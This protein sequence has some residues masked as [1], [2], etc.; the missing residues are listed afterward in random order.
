MRTKST[1]L[2]GIQI[3]RAISVLS[4]LLFHFD[5][6]FSR[7]YLG[8]DIFFVISGFV[9]TR[10]SLTK[11][12]DRKLRQTINF[13]ASRT[14]R[15][16]PAFAVMN[17][18]VLI[19]IILFLSPNLGVQQQAIKSGFGSMLGISN[20][21]IP[22]LTGDYFGTPS[23]LNPYLH[24][25]SLSV[26]EQFYLLFP[27][28]LVLVKTKTR[29]KPLKIFYKFFPEVLFLI[30]LY[31]W[32]NLERFPALASIAPTYF[33]PISRFWEFLAGVIA[34]RIVFEKSSNSFRLPKVFNKAYFIL[35]LALLNLENF[36]PTDILI[37]VVSLTFFMLIFGD[38]ELEEKQETRLEKLLERVGDRSYSIYLWH[39]PIIVI[40]PLAVNGLSH[41]VVLVIALALTLVASEISFRTIEVKVKRQLM[42]RNLLIGITNGV[43]FITV[44]MSMVVGAAFVQS[45]MNQSWALTSHLA[46]KDDC[47]IGLTAQPV[48][49]E[50]T[51]KWEPT[52]SK[53][54]GESI[55]LYGDSLAW[56]GADSA[57]TSANAL[58]Y[59][60]RLFT[61]NGCYARLA[62][63]SD[64]SPCGEWSR[65]VFKEIQ[66]TKPSILI[67]YGNFQ[68]DRL[69]SETLSLLRNL[70]LI[71][72]KTIIVMPPPMGDSF[73]EI[74]GIFNFRIKPD[75]A[76]GR[77][78]PVEIS[79]EFK[80]GLFMTF[81]PADVICSGPVCPI[82]EKGAEL[83][84]YGNHLSVYGNGKLVEPLKALILRFKEM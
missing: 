78:Q 70:E 38:W 7:G 46:I 42:N 47:D 49:L 83:Y 52:K 80:G 14:L 72:Q 41:P 13:Y 55:Y 44:F 30:S 22:R 40:L 29:R 23:Q 25:W 15:L 27:I 71:R 31:L 3:L 43:L 35:I 63:I 50:K 67:L 19:W 10:S 68:N 48:T 61:R 12:E 81:E 26:E 2:P 66:L 60:V 62:N 65:N 64:S 51:C 9:I 59:T 11:F 58:G 21:L 5:V 28:L 84:N 32:F 54:A 56:S 79:S 8:V 4:V 36:E 37:I 1:F 6:G 57:I 69:P 24:T 74:K 53:E 39:W 75:R 16:F 18:V 73:S 76:G 82:A 34:A 33:S 17:F 77:P 45:G 20:L